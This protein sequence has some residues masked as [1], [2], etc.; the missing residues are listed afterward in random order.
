MVKLSLYQ[1]ME[2]SLET[3]VTRVGGCVRWSPACE[4]MNPAAE[5]RPLLEGVTNQRSE[6]RD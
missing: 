2:D 3:R 5:E 1:T 6:D 4:D